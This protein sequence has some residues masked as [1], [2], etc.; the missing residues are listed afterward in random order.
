MLSHR[1]THLINRSLTSGVFPTSENIAKVTA[2]YKC[3]SKSELGNY[4]QISVLAV[5][6]KTIEEVVHQQITTRLESTNLISSTQFGF[7]RS[8]SRQHAVTYF[9]VH[10]KLH[11]DQNMYTCAV[12][13][14]LKKAFDTVQEMVHRPPL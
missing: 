11:T 12:F 10:I 14:D 9:I 8:R 6:S 7:R 13:M 5:F 1:L 4:R 3:D 2:V